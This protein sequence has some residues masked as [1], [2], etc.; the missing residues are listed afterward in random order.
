MKG[1]LVASFKWT[2]ASAIFV[3]SVFAISSPVATAD[4][5]EL[6]IIWTCDWGLGTG[7]CGSD[8]PIIQGLPGVPRKSCGGMAPAVT[9]C[10]SWVGAG[11]NWRVAIAVSPG[12]SGSI[13]AHSQ[14]GGTESG[15]HLS[16][17]IILQTIP[18]SPG[19]SLASCSGGT[20][21]PQPSNPGTVN[22]IGSTTALG[23]ICIGLPTCPA[24]GAWEVRIYT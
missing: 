8:L 10:S 2:W 22:F 17:S 12:F 14:M 15:I 7:T 21:G 23:T 11:T 5:P 20:F 3:G 24:V 16:C 6:L 13:L 19:P 18:G 9:Y 1:R 4:D